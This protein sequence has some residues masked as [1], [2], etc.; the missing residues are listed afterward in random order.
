[1][2]RWSF[3][4][5]CCTLTLAAC[6]TSATGPTFSSQT[7]PAAPNGY[8]RVYLFRDKVLYL[9]QAPYIAQAQIA[10]DGR[11]VGNLA[12]GGYLVTNIVAGRHSITSGSGAYQTTRVFDAAS[13]G[14]GYI[15]IIDKTR[16]EGARMV[17]EGAIGALA[18][19]GNAIHKVSGAM[20]AISQD[21][22]F[23]GPERV[24]DISFPS[25]ADALPRLSLL[26]SNS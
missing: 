26:L 14:D 10:I 20:D 19:G 1:M 4:L 3:I 25:R 6:A 24:W 5:L 15:E 21:E 2:K 18:A 7:P 9:A 23:S 16:M 11:T 12:N 13:S 22:S 8:V 17:A